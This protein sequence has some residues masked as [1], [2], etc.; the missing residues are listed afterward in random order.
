[1]ARILSLITFTSGL[2]LRFGAR[3]E[4]LFL[5]LWPV[6]SG[7]GFSSLQA[8]CCELSATVGEVSQT[9]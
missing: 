9:A 4:V 7:G 8:I 1:M 6:A 2:H 3:T 5:G